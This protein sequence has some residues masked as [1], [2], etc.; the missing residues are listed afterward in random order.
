MT[1]ITKTAL[2][3]LVNEVLNNRSFGVNEEV[4]VSDKV[5][6]QLHD[7][8]PFDPDFKPRS[9]DE[10]E[11]MIDS[12]IRNAD[13]PEE[14]MAAVGDNVKK[15]ISNA[16]TSV[17]LEEAVRLAVRNALKEAA[18]VEAQEQDD[19]KPK[20]HRKF[21]TATDVGGDS[22]KTIAKE[23]GFSIAGAKSAVDRAMRKAQFLAKMDSDD[24][25]LLVLYSVK[26]YIDFLRGSGELE[27]AD[28]QFM[29]DHPTE[30]EELD[31][32]REFLAKRIKEEQELDGEQDEQG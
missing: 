11:D 22:F 8:D 3:Q 18:N 24:L 13:I 4:N 29:L 2:R 19:D 32:F 26:D 6:P 27:D 5:D 16:S 20:K 23:L 31:G 10:L 17:G 30:V 9:K 14:R 1:T 25:E 28:V 12:C 15:V 7:V 21:D